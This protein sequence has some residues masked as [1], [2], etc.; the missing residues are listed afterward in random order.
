[1]IEIVFND[2]KKYFLYNRID[3]L[4]YSLQIYSKCHDIVKYLIVNERIFIKV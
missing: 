2:N 3:L 1:M 4:N